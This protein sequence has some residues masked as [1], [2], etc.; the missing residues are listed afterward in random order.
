M[1]S[2]KCDKNGL[3]AG[4]QPCEKGKDS[5]YSQSSPCRLAQFS[6]IQGGGNGQG[7]GSGEQ[8]MDRERRSEKIRTKEIEGGLFG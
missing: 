4:W 1:N 8:E 2:F 3:G 5:L 6:K 7:G